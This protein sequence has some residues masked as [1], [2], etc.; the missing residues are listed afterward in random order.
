MQNTFN[1]E[2]INNNIQ[3]MTS[4]EIDCVSG[5]DLG[6]SA[7]ALGL[8]GTIGVAAYGSGWGALA[9]GAAFAAAPI[10]V[11]AMVGLGGYA[12]YLMLRPKSF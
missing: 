3:E 1:K 6:A 11:I 9:V 10:A 4:D 2:L 7:K 12:G 5:A 8:A